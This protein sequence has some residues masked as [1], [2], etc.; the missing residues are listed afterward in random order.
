M[1]QLNTQSF[2]ELAPAGA[3]TGMGLPQINPIDMLSHAELGDLMEW[4]AN[5]PVMTP[6]QRQL[7]RTYGKQGLGL[8]S[9]SF[10]G[11]LGD[12]IGRT[13]SKW[14]FD[15]QAFDIPLNLTDDVSQSGGINYSE[16]VLDN[17]INMVEEN[18]VPWEQWGYIFEAPTLGDFRDRLERTVLG[19]PD[20]VQFGG[21][22]GKALGFA[23][24]TSGLMLLGATMEAPLFIGTGL[25]AAAQ[26]TARVSRASEI[27]GRSVTVANEAAHWANNMSRLGFLGRSAALG[28][29]EE[30]VV[31]GIQYSTDPTFVGDAERLAWDYT[32]AVGGWT[33]VGGL[34]GKSVAKARY[35]KEYS[36]ALK[37][38]V[39]PTGLNLVE[40]RGPL[41]FGT[42]AL[43][44]MFMTDG[45]DRLSATITMTGDDLHKAWTT[46]PGVEN[47][48]KDSSVSGIE[49]AAL[50]IM[51]DIDKR[52]AGSASTPEM[53]QK[54]SGA[55]WDA[56]MSGAAK[57][58]DTAFWN[59]VADRLDGIAPKRTIQK[60]RRAAKKDSILPSSKVDELFMGLPDMDS[61]K[62]L[63]EL[64]DSLKSGA[65]T[66]EI[67][68]NLDA[69]GERSFTVALLREMTNRGYDANVKGV[70]TLLQDWG[71]VIRNP[72]L[73]PNGEID[74][75]GLSVQI[76]DIANKVLPTDRAIE[77]TPG[78]KAKLA[79]L[80]ANSAY[81]LRAGVLQPGPGMPT[82]AG[83][84]RTEEEGYKLIDLEIPIL[85]KWTDVLPFGA[86]WMF[87]QA[88]PIL[89]SKNWLSRLT[90]YTGFNARRVMETKSGRIVAQERTD[91]ERG[92]HR[93]TVV[94]SEL[95]R[96]VENAFL[97]FALG[98]NPG[99]RI[100]RMDAVKLSF[101]SGPTARRK[102]LNEFNER[103]VVQWSTRKFDDSVEAIN[104]AARK[105]VEIYGPGTG[106]LFDEA[107][108][109]QIPG[110]RNVKYANYVPHHWLGNVIS[111]IVLDPQGK[112]ALI[113][114]IRQ[115]MI[116][117]GVTDPTTGK[118]LRQMILDNGKV[119]E[120]D[121]IDP[122]AEV[123]VNTLI[124]RAN[125]MNNAPLTQT[126]TALMDALAGLQGPI[127]GDK[128]MRARA[129]KG[130]VN[131]NTTTKVD[132]GI[133]LLGKG[134]TE[135]R[136]LDLIDNDVMR[137]TRDWANSVQGAINE[138]RVLA[139]M[140]ALFES[141]GLLAPIRKTKKG[142]TRK[143]KPL[144]IKSLDQI[145]KLANKIGTQYPKLFGGQLGMMEESALKEMINAIRMV[146]VVRPETPQDLEN[147]SRIGSM[148]VYLATG[149]RF[150]M[151]QISE[152]FRLVGTYGLRN[153]VTELPTMKEVVS[154]WWNMGEGPK[155]AVILISDVF[156]IGVDRRMRNILRAS[157]IDTERVGGVLAKPR[158]VLERTTTVFSDIE[159]LAPVTSMT[160]YLAASSAL[161]HL[162]DVA[163]NRVKA[164]DDATVR[165]WG[166]EPNQ[167]RELIAWVGA[168][169]QTY[170]KMGM[171]RI[172]GF[173][174]YD[175]EVMDKLTG[176]VN[177]ATVTRIQDYATRGDMHQVAFSWWGRL[178]LQ[179]QSFTLKGVDNLMF[180]NLSRVT[181]GDAQSRMQVAKELAAVLV[182]AWLVK[183][184]MNY[185][186]WWSA[187]AR[188]DT[189]E[190]ERLAKKL[191]AKGSVAEAMNYV[192]DAYLPML[193]FEKAYSTFI[194][195]GGL[196]EDYR[197][198]QYG[199]Y[200]VPILS[201]F[202]RAKEVTEDVT[203]KLLYE[204]TG[205]EAVH[206]DITTSTLHK[207][208]TLLPFQNL[209][210]MKHVFNVA[211][212][213]IA[214]YLELPEQ[215]KA[216]KR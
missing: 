9:S 195:R 108:K 7:E 8:A 15:D 86:K 186:D 175:P 171:T 54:I 18:N 95:G 104:D 121:D 167:Y 88:A 47:A 203:G 37:R 158:R 26:G 16:N 110:F 196:S 35:E 213:D 85:N 78:A 71:R 24:D 193:A 119:F 114:L 57:G 164:M 20:T 209:W 133:D 30:S 36:Q 216:R 62:M 89:T 144:K 91:V 4:E 172:K 17:L 139:K 38:Y 93:V 206:R 58:G 43:D 197:A 168:N 191:E 146:P 137:V 60:V 82:A 142:K 117:A 140:N 11:Y 45:A 136:I 90:A 41:E 145:I 83:P 51:W 66:P 69:I 25:R 129:G 169:A 156:G 27:F 113:K 102:K 68:A 152:T 77:M 198:R 32:M 204:I 48:I 96:T 123:F 190:A 127:K 202:T 61:Y 84:I 73:L 199:G 49:R 63:D 22:W 160:Q 94:N 46:M 176:F 97:R 178:L 205:N 170:R 14:M 100:T 201:Q 174:N 52:V 179:F 165:S 148:A 42:S 118:A 143:P 79:M 109:L 125:N 150:V 31:K 149:G 115:A 183:Y 3:P 141:Y 23:S 107:N 19:N 112:Q 67:A 29:A 188:G 76:I 12:W 64:V 28:I 80:S 53:A 33:V 103:V 181:R 151:G 177:R 81:K 72:P 92:Y 194:D 34:F 59:A 212:D 106:S 99:D 215:Q 163:R 154:N 116:D 120:Y 126:E 153:V 173:K 159:G 1:T 5:D 101:G 70:M 208:R 50:A 210:Y 132:V 162:H 187:D 74:E 2:P 10:T 184:A 135:L 98:K 105:L 185:S 21:N 122:A 87:N 65:T 192:G 56:H 180:Q 55:I 166:L 44:T 214:G 147:I 131:L 155:S 111:K 75:A 207:F 39:T 40:W 13:A 200:S 124:E 6:V 138:H 157:P 189:E 161:H 128:A 182:G 130:R 211:E 134:T